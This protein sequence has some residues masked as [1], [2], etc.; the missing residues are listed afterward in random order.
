MEFGDIKIS[1][2]RLQNPLLAFR[3]QRAYRAERGRH[4][5]GS[6]RT[7]RSGVDLEV[8]VPIGTVVL[9]EDGVL[10]LANT[11]GSDV[12]DFHAEPKSV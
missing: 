10:Q 7:G 1:V 2:N 11:N 3:Y 8:R 9:D 4:G 6:K 12:N 5:E